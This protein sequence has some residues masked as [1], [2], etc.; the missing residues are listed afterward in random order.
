MSKRIFEYV[1]EAANSAKWWEV[2]IAV[3]PDD[4]SGTAR[5]TFSWGRCGA[6]GQTQ[7]K[8]MKELALQAEVVKRVEGQL[9]EG[10]RPV[11]RKHSSAQAA[12]DDERRRLGVPSWSWGGR[13]A[14]TQIKERTSA[15]L[16]EM[17]QEEARGKLLDEVK[18]AQLI[19]RL[20]ETPDPR[21]RTAMKDRFMNEVAI[22]GRRPLI[23]G[24]ATTLGPEQAAQCIHATL[25]PVVKGDFT[26]LRCRECG[27]IVRTG[28][29][30]QPEPL[31]ANFERPKRTIEFDDDK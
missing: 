14:P 6:A 9:R 29:A 4:P 15:Q 16:R 30:A 2:E 21:E 27:V 10:Y 26:S 22:P 19:A 25:A 3:E 1:D 17:A 31:K 11:E 23:M 20:K 12:F 13:L 28:I 18:R 7:V 5:A 8:I 24:K